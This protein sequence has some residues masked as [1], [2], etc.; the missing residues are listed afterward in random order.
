MILKILSFITDGKQ[1]LAL[2]NNPHPRHGGDFWF[3]VT[4]AIE[5]EESDKDAVTREI[6][7]ETGLESEEILFLNWGSIYDWKNKICRELNFITF[8]K[9][10]KIVL[11]EEHVQYEWLNLKDFVNKIKWGDNKEIL[12]IVLR[13][14]V[15]KEIYFKDETIED[16]TLRNKK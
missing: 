16:Y 12:R 7:E 10:G 6:K 13:K 14:A 1:F 3:V 8:V 15:N 5:G 11:N 9:K 4:G 2:R